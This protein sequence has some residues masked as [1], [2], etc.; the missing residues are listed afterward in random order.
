M[1]NKERLPRAHLM[2]VIS[3]LASFIAFT[4]LTYIILSGCPPFNG[5][6]DD[7]IMEKISKGTF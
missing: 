7:I 5:A 2:N 3:V 1:E 6:D 4:I